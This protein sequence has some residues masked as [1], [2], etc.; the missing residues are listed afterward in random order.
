MDTQLWQGKNTSKLDPKEFKPAQNETLWRKP[1]K[2]G[3]WTS[4]YDEKLG[5][6]W[7][8]WGIAEDYNN[9]DDLIF[10]NCWLLYPE[11]NINVYEIDTY[12]DLENLC[13]KASQSYTFGE[14]S[15]HGPYEE[16]YPDWEVLAQEYDAIHLT[17]NGQCETRLSRPLTLYG[18]DCESTLWLQWKFAKVEYIGDLQV[19]EQLH[20]YS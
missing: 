5:S 19:H 12:A 8:Q 15:P 2:G 9:P 10:K 1:K 14:T 16:T 11:A 13:K 20:S 6:D 7:L 17:V 18:W 3:L 4:T